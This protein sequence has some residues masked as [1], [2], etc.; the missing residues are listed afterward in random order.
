MTETTKSRLAERT[1]VSGR[2][3]LALGGAVLLAVMILGLPT[4]AQERSLS[5]WRLNEWSTWESLPEVNPYATITGLG[6]GEGWGNSGASIGVTARAVFEPDLSRAEITAE[7]VPVSRGIITSDPRL[8]IAPLRQRLE[9]KIIVTVRNPNDVSMTNVRVRNQFGKAFR[10]ALTGQSVGDARMAD[11]DVKG[12][13]PSS[14]GLTWDIGYLGP[15]AAAKAELTVATN[16]TGGRAEFAE[17]GVYSLDTGFQLNYRLLGKD[18]VRN[19]APCS[20]IARANPSAL[21]PDGEPYAVQQ[22]PIE[23]DLLMHQRPVP[24]RPGPQG[25]GIDIPGNRQPAVITRVPGG[26]SQNGSRDITRAKELFSITAAGVSPN[27]TDDGV[28]FR[29]PPD[30]A[31]EWSVTLDVE[32]T[33]SDGWNG[34]VVTLTFGPGLQVPVYGATMRVTDEYGN[35]VPYVG[36]LRL[37]PQGSG[38]EATDVT[39]TWEASGGKFE[40]G[41]KAQLELQVTTTGLPGG[42]GESVFCKSIRMEY[43]PET[44][45]PPPVY[46]DDVNIAPVGEPYA[47]VSLSATRLDWRVR[48]PGTYAT[49]ATE[50]IATGYGKLQVQFSDFRDLARTNGVSGMVPAFYA[51]GQDLPGNTSLQWI[52]ASAMNDPLSWPIPMVLDSTVGSVLRL[53]SM[54]DVDEEVSSAEYSSDRGEGKGVITFIVSNN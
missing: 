23:R 53:W 14:S 36:T 52:A 15:G 2:R 31:A 6:S 3:G 9:W 50:I 33:Q 38:P 10:A 54:I 42:A 5:A 43:D 49:L 8:F 47:C 1:Q 22:K 35:V 24:V 26:G 11:G 29:V 48:R 46:L 27:V 16:Q 12:L 28:R 25:P 51:F 21:R 19:T 45:D 39:W 41:F 20:V 17:E 34:W 18:E 40:P 7:F 13:L 44:G 4:I 37:V 30:Q 32:N